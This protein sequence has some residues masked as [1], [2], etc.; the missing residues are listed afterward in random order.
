M[1]V[2]T[3]HTDFTKCRRHGMS[4]LEHGIAHV[5]HLKLPFKG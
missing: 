5:T 2:S 4:V 1:W 3:E